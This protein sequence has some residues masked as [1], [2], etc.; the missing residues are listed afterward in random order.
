[1][2]LDFKV[3]SIYSVW[4]TLHIFI[5]I[6]Q[7]NQ[8]N[9]KKCYIITINKLA[10]LC[11]YQNNVNSVMQATSYNLGKLVNHTHFLQLFFY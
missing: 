1:M 5:Y 11:L 8:N 10:L 9:I 4:S 3:L 7:T 6:T 2:I